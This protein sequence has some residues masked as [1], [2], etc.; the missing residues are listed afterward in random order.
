MRDV[1]ETSLLEIRR[2][3]G[4]DT[5]R[6]TGVTVS[7]CYISIRN[8]HVMIE[9]ADAAIETAAPPRAQSFKGGQCNPTDIAEPKPEADAGATETEETH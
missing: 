4:C 6:N 5:I 3:D 7:I 9:V 8:I 2:S 1:T